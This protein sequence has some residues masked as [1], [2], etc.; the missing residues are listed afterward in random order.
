M[1]INPS[2]RKF[3]ESN[4]KTIIAFDKFINR[5][6][7][8]GWNLERV[9]AEEETKHE[10]DFDNISCHLLKSYPSSQ[11]N[12]DALKST[13][14]LTGDLSQDYQDFLLTVDGFTLSQSV[15]KDGWGQKFSLAFMSTYSQ[16]RYQQ[17]RSQMTCL[18]D[19]HQPF[20]IISTI[21]DDSYDFSGAVML[22]SD[23]K[24]EKIENDTITS[25]FD[26]F[27]EYFRY[28]IREIHQYLSYA[29]YWVQ[30]KAG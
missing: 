18:Q 22:L 30:R 6:L 4:E 12:I 24:I 27:E 15:S 20:L 26:S 14:G 8:N 13:I 25:T 9:V 11:T 5:R 28:E 19:I 10:K 29:R 23:N 3:F 17:D 2:R 1:K 21:N 7:K 16:S